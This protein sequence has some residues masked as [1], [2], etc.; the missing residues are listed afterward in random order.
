MATTY[1]TYE[2]KESHYM[3]LLLH[4]QQTANLLPNGSILITHVNQVTDI[5]QET[6]RCFSIKS[7]LSVVA[8]IKSN[9]LQIATISDLQNIHSDHHY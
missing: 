9:V 6:K 3:Q 5:E 8:S 7:G 2:E 1:K 4:V